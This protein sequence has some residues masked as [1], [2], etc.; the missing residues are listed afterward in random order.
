MQNATGM[1]LQPSWRWEEI[2]VYADKA[3]SNKS[4]FTN[5]EGNHVQSFVSERD[6]KLSRIWADGLIFKTG[7]DS[8]ANDFCGE[9]GIVGSLQPSKSESIDQ[10]SLF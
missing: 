8:F 2:F 4:V 7:C 6:K 9:N 3:D 5:Q 1:P 10:I